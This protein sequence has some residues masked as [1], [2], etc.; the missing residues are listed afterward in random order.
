MATIANPRLLFTRIPSGLPTAEDV[1]TYDDLNT[2]DLEAHL[3][4]GFLVKVLCLSLD[5][6]MRNRMRPVETRGDMPAFQL[7]EVY[8]ELSG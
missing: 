7:G 2:I 8:A 6:Y 3:H 1:F 4:G 5:P